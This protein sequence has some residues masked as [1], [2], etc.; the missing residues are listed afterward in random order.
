[1]VIAARRKDRLAALAEEVQA[2]GAA[3]VT[4]VEMDVSNES[5][6]QAAFNEID[7]T[8]PALDVVISTA[9]LS[10]DGLAIGLPVGDF[11]VALLA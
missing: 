10:G 5:S 8:G 7:A 2:L 1:M 3:A 11:D 9:G 4:A 6:V